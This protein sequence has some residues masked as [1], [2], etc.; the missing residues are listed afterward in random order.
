MTFTYFQILHKIQILK[1]MMNSFL[2]LDIYIHI[3]VL[4]WV[5]ENVS[6]EFEF[7]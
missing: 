7:I 5:Q 2:C 6:F 4:Q 1:N 3:F